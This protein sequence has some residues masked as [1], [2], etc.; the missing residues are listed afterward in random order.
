MENNIQIISIDKKIY[1]L[2]KD[3]EGFPKL[4]RFNEKYNILIEIKFNNLK[5]KNTNEIVIETLSKQ[6]INRIKKEIEKKY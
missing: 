6:Y 3:K 5:L 4:M 1:I 2:Q